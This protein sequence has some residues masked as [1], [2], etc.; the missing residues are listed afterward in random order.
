MPGLDGDIEYT[1]PIYSG[2]DVILTWID[3]R[4][5][6]KVFSTTLNTNGPNPEFQN[7]LALTEFDS[8]TFQL[9]NEPVTLLAH[10]FLFTAAFDASSGAKLVRINKFDL[11]YQMQWPTGGYI[12]YQG[13][14]DQRKVHLFKVQDGIGNDSSEN[15]EE[16]D[17]EL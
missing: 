16:I 17:F 11:E 9:E 8:Y 6:K 2:N 10:D 1:N 7:G 13:T 4:D 12:V 15:R 14:A 5:G 3:A